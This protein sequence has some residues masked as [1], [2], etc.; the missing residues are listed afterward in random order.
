MWRLIPKDERFFDIFNTM[1]ENADATAALLVEMMQNADNLQDRA[2]AIKGKE[3]LGDTYTH[4]LI[5]KLHST[6]VTPLDREDIHELASSIDDIVDLAD[7]AANRIV[8]FD[9]TGPIHGALDLARVLRLQTQE[10]R[11]AVQMLSE[12]SRIL[13]RCVEI[14][15]LENEGDRV[16]Q[17][18]MARLFKTEKDP[19]RLIK[20]KEVLESLERATDTCEDVANV[21]EGII[22]KNA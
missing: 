4:D 12:Q 16:F 6:F 13:E 19:I 8:L 22:V 11:K 2:S 10:I 3:H 7:A 1:A 18:A 17:D 14:H 15:R 5:R 20:H 21:L 9:I